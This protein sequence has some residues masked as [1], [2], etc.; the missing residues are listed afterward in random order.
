M[1]SLKGKIMVSVFQIHCEDRKRTIGSYE[2]MKRVDQFYDPSRV[3]LV[4]S[5]ILLFAQS[6]PFS[7]ILPLMIVQKLIF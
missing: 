7:Q 1:A 2:V 6:G 4:H 5:E 3:I